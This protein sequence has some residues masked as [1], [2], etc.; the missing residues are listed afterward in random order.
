M[1]KAQ[2]RALLLQ[3]C[4][5]G[6]P[7]SGPAASV[8]TSSLPLL[9]VCV[10]PSEEEAGNQTAD[11]STCN[12]DDVATTTI[13][14]HRSV[15]TL[16][17]IL[18]CRFPEAIEDVAT[19]F[20]LSNYAPMS[21]LPGV[22][23]DPSLQL[24]NPALDALRATS[25]AYLSMTLPPSFSPTLT[26]TTSVMYG[27]ALSHT[28][29]S[30][31]DPCTAAADMTLLAVLLLA[32]F[33]SLSLRGPSSRIAWLAHA[34]GT[35]ALLSL[36]KRQRRTNCSSP[37]RE[38]DRLAAR[39]VRISAV[40]RA[41]PVQFENEDFRREVTAT[42]LRTDD[43]LDHITK[44]R[45]LENLQ[46]GVGHD[47]E[48]MRRTIELDAGIALRSAAPLPRPGPGPEYARA[49]RSWITMR[50]VR[51]FL[52]QKLQSQ[53]SDSHVPEVLA[54][55]DV[56][57]RNSG[58]VAAEIL[59]MVP[60][61]L[62]AARGGADL[63]T[64]ARHLIWPL[65]LFASSNSCPAPGRECLW[66]QLKEIM[67]QWNLVPS[68]EAARLLSGSTHPGDWYDALPRYFWAP[69]CLTGTQ[70]PSLPRLLKRDAL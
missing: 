20:F 19:C 33:E 56:G 59:T 15:D 70:A 58:Q 41:E 10:R 39:Q 26:R 42:E 43:L 8:R 49:A 5:P 66:R 23:S 25:L 64:V 32:L 37:G 53:D 21:N 45:H 7:S 67:H 52:N 31:A 1:R 17:P 4:S 2:K 28:N 29:A 57:C 69:S 27:T 51:L 9:P 44:L 54:I 63:A 22:L 12:N 62:E 14:Q 55:R 68:A 46:K 47:L 60:E 16:K 36:R 30:L 38:L 40:L 34:R 50:I 24:T 48:A 18:S 3:D 35:Q 11:S 13:K 61:F 65:A 6:A